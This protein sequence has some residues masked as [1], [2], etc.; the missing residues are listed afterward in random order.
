MQFEALLRFAG[1]K[2]LNQGKVVEYVARL[3]N[4]CD[5]NSHMAI[6]AYDYKREIIENS[7]MNIIIGRSQP[8]SSISSARTMRHLNEITQNFTPQQLT[9]TASSGVEYFEFQSD[10]AVYWEQ[11]HGQLSHE[12]AE[13]FVAY[14]TPTIFVNRFIRLFNARQTQFVLKNLIFNSR[15]ND[16]YVCP[17]NNDLQIVRITIEHFVL[18]DVHSNDAT[19]YGLA[20]DAEFETFGIAQMLRHRYNALNRINYE[21]LAGPIGLSG[22]MCCRLA[23]ARQTN[24]DFEQVLVSMNAN[25]LLTWFEQFIN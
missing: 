15:V 11:K 9:L 22:V 24:E 18:I 4:L 12:Q 2:N 6:D 14:G 20:T 7:L 10:L 25:S 1:F 19:V 5:Q 23:L 3:A 21:Q 17:T 16:Q 13:R 8:G